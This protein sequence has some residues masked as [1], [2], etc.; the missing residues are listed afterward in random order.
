MKKQ[1]FTLIITIAIVAGVISL[2]IGSAIFGEVKHDLKAPQVESIKTS[3]PDAQN[4]PAYQAF[5][6]EKALD[7]TQP[8]QIGNTRN[9]VPFNQ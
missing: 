9:T 7:P 3:F 6:N 1:D 8:I 5:L 4:E 2:L